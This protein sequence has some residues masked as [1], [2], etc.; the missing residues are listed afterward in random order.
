VVESLVQVVEPGQ[1]SAD[2]LRRCVLDRVELLLSRTLFV[3]LEI[4]LASAVAASSSA[5][6]PSIE[7]TCLAAAASIVSWCRSPSWDSCGYFRVVM[8]FD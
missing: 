3:V 4:G 7:A 6:L 2:Q 5:I 1:K 8:T